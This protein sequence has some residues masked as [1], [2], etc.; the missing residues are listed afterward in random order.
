MVEV[1]KT[2][3][4]TTSLQYYEKLE[5]HIKKPYRNIKKKEASSIWDIADVGENTCKKMLEKNNK[6]Y[7]VPKI[8]VALSGFLDVKKEIE[9]NLKARLPKKY[10]FIPSSENN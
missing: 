8:Q 6:N 3:N 4:D 2:A 5:L 10:G 7:L 1:A 9:D